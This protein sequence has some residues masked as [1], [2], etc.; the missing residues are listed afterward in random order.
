MEEPAAASWYPI[1]SL[2]CWA[3]KASKWL[4]WIH[5]ISGTVW[6]LP[7]GGRM[8]CVLILIDDLKTDGA[9]RVEYDVVYHR[10]GRIHISYFVSVDAGPVH[11]KLYVYSQSMNVIIWF[12]LFKLFRYLKW[13]TSVWVYNTTTRVLLA[14]SSWNWC[15]GWCV[16]FFCSCVIQP[17]LWLHTITSRNI[18]RRCRTKGWRGR[19]QALHA[20]LQYWGST[21]GTEA[22]ARWSW[23]LLPS[24]H[25][26]P[27]GFFLWHLISCFFPVAANFL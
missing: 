17:C 3:S 15:T 23:Q 19:T 18:Y 8:V 14:L 7:G 21:C 9:G 13:T 24:T 27:Q 25:H 20:A 1:S 6:A 12:T 16:I 4:P 2:G 26:Q 10:F 11:L 22:W 5:D